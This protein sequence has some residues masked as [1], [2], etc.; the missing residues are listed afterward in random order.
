M[1]GNNISSP[2]RIHFG[3]VPISTSDNMV[4]KPVPEHSQPKEKKQ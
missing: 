4:L 1:F 3:L 2:F